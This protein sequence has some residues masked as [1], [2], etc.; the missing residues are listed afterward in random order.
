MRRSS[1][2]RSRPQSHA[3]RRDRPR[4][5]GPR[6]T[7]ARWSG[8]WRRDP[9]HPLRQHDR[10]GQLHVA[11]QPEPGDGDA[12]R[13]PSGSRRR[14]T[15]RATCSTSAASRERDDDPL[16]PGLPQGHEE[17]PEDQHRQRRQLQLLDQHRQ[18]A[19]GDGDRLGQEVRRHL[20]RRRRGRHRHPAGVRRLEG[21]ADPAERGRGGDERQPAPRDPEQGAAAMLQFPP[22]DSKVCIET[23]SR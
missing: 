10:L 2:P 15:T 14:C 12:C 7:P 17:V 4:A 9:R 20:G 18:A 3:S 16:R 11:R 23:A 6:P 1:C 13:S 5:L 21:P 19:G 22:A 8:R